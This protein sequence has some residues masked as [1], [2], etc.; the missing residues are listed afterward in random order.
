MAGMAIKEGEAVTGRERATEETEKVTGA[1]HHRQEN[2]K[3]DESL[4]LVGWNS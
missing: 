3:T 1:Q 2:L 4:G